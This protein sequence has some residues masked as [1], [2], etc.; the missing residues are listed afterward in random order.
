MARQ[1][2]LDEKL[3]DE[4]RKYLIARGRRYLVLQN[5]RRFNSKTS[6]PA[7]QEAK[8]PEQAEWERQVNELTVAELRDELS[9]RGLDTKGN[10]Q[11]LRD[12]LIQAGPEA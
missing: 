10:Q 4:D 5:D 8:S 11:V 3:S 7:P 6:S 12:R 1:I 2:N 9:N